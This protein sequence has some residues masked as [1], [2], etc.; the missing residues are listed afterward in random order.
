MKQNYFSLVLDSWLDKKKQFNKVFPNF[1]N[2]FYEIKGR[3]DTRI[4][5]LIQ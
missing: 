1:W 3:H 4:S 2:T 5:T